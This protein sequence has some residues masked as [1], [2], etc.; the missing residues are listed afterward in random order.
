MAWK[1][2]FYITYLQNIII[3]PD[4]S[5]FMRNSAIILASVGLA[6]IMLVPGMSFAMTPNAPPT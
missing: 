3:Y 1:Y 6:L 4:T 2:I 5:L